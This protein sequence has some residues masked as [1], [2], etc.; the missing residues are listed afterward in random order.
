PNGALATWLMM[1]LARTCR[2]S[3]PRNSPR[4]GSRSKIESSKSVAWARGSSARV[5]RSC[6]SAI[7]GS[8]AEHVFVLRYTLNFRPYV[9]LRP[10]RQ[11]GRVGHSGG[12]P[13]FSGSLTVARSLTFDRWYLSAVSFVTT[14]V[15]TLSAGAGVVS[16][17]P[18]GSAFDLA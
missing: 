17:N 10:M 18:F 5:Q 2:N 4:P 3:M 15:F 11:Y 9:D 14:N 12:P 16:V 1:R 13:N 8:L 7:D 6:P